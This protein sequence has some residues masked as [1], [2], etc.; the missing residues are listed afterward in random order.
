MF[1]NAPEG[2]VDDAEI[3]SVMFNGMEIDGIDDED[4]EADIAEAPPMDRP[5]KRPVGDPIKTVYISR[6][7]HYGNVIR[8]KYEQFG[9]RPG[10]LSVEDESDGY[11]TTTV[12][13]M[14]RF[15]SSS[16]IIS[17]MVDFPQR[18]TPERIFTSGAFTKGSI[19]FT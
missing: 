4:D 9:G 8:A 10:Y 17:N 2:D 1:N 11:F 19:A 7:N 15:R 12:E 14:P 18:R 3:E 16:F 13:N 6:E 5:F